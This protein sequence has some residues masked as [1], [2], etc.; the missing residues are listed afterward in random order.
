[1]GDLKESKQAVGASILTGLADFA[2]PTILGQAGRMQ[3]RQRFFNMVVTNVPGP[4]FPL[5]LM[6]RELQAVFP[7]V[8]LAKR[9]AVCFGIM[10]YNG[11]VNFG[12]IGDY[13]AMADIDSLAHDLSESI[14]E[15]A[16]LAPP[17]GRRAR[18]R[19]DGSGLRAPVS[20]AIRPAAD[21]DAAAI[22]E[23][24][25]QGVAER[26]ATFR[27]EP[28]T[29]ADVAVAL[30]TRTADARRRARREDRR[31]GRNRPLRRRQRLVLGH[32]RGRGLRRPRRPPRR[33]RPGAAATPS[34]GP[35]RTPASTS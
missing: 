2:P 24:H 30:A 35:P 11:Q 17:E 20:T 21:A 4:Q 1:M 15:L 28:R 7:M 33:C 29:P 18:S 5:Y 3:S 12:L 25:N 23:I 26:I 27:S 14:A 13:D 34:S 32:R 6:G 22:A 10:S 16:A 31:L 19:P 8:P 9:Q